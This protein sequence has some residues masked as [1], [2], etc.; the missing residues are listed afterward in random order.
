M[1][2]G[3]VVVEN[4]LSDFNREVAEAGNANI[5]TWITVVPTIVDEALK[6]VIVEVKNSE[7]GINL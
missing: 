1:I 6:V 3:Y 2:P 7:G 4:E 5:T